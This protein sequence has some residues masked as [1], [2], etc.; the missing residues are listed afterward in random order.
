M[1]FVV[2]LITYR[3]GVQVTPRRE[4]EQTDSLGESLRLRRQETNK[5]CH[6]PL[7]DPKLFRLLLRIDQD[8][9]ESTRQ[10]GCHC[11]GRLHRANYPRKPR[12]CPPEIRAEFAS[13]LSFCCH[14]CRRRTTSRSVR[15]LGRRVYLAL[16]MVLVGSR[17]AGQS[18]SAHALSKAVNI[19]LRTLQ[20]WRAW[21]QQQFVG[22]PLWQVHRARFMPPVATALLPASLLTRF[23]ATGPAA[24][25]RLLVF[26]SPITVRLITLRA[27]R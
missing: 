26:L 19:S 5:V 7:Q 15:F 1:V 12:G 4:L 23:A 16:V 22:T 24:L 3:D 17:H 8:L 21:W 11:G 2:F 13:R 25:E 27:G 9:A 14:R 6:I 10:A 20:R 18:G